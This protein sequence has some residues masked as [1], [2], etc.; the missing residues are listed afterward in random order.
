VSQLKRLDAK[1]TKEG[2]AGQCDGVKGDFMKLPFEPNTFD[3]VYTI[4]ATCHAPDRTACFAQIFT[5]LKPGKMF[6]GCVSAQFPCA[7]P[8]CHVVTQRMTNAATS[9]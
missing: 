7:W 9:G 3:A 5:V 8:R 1:V 4:E 6:C 2:L